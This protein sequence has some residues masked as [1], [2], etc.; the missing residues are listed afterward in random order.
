MQVAAA[1]SQPNRS[2]WLPHDALIGIQPFASSPSVASS[3]TSLL[4][5]FRV[6]A[7]KTNCM[8]PAQARSVAIKNP[9]SG[10]ANQRR[11]L[12]SWRDPLCVASAR[13][14]SLSLS[15]YPPTS[16]TQAHASTHTDPHANVRI[17]TRFFRAHIAW[18]ADFRSISRHK[19]LEQATASSLP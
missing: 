9:A 10:G 17:M 2:N 8:L 1:V 14:L 12:Y 19:Q 6:R 3:R 18:P 5:S 15:F 4:T 13:S 7:F 16:D 11:H